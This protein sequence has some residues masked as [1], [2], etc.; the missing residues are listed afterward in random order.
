MAGGVL[1]AGA[2]LVGILAYFG[3]QGTTPAAQAQ[4]ACPADSNCV[5]VTKD[6]GG[7]DEPDFSFNSSEG[8]FSLN[9]G[10][11]ETLSIDDNGTI[12]VSEDETDGWSLVDIDCDEPGEV[13]VD[14]NGTSVEVD[15]S[16]LADDEFETVNCTFINEMD[17]TPT[18]TSTATATATATATS[19]TSAGTATPTRTTVVIGQATNTPVPTAT[20]GGVIS[21]PSTGDGGLK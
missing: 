14:E 16:G 21:P 4:E 6:A 5:I 2:L 12:T 7:D 20:S 9:D 11:S 10:E 18:S 15:F 1:A 8:D 17:A 19:T 3:G 13:S